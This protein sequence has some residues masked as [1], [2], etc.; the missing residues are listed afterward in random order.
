MDEYKNSRPWYAYNEFEVLQRCQCTP[1]IG[2]D[3]PK[4]M[5]ER[6]FEGRDLFKITAK[7]YL[8][9]AAGNGADGAV[10]LKET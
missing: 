2:I 8:A 5:E 7:E 4:F 1:P 6:D 3:L 10:Y 9:M